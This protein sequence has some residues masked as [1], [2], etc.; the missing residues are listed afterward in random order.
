MAQVEEWWAHNQDLQ[1]PDKERPF[2]V[3]D[4][5]MIAHHGGGAVLDTWAY[6]DGNNCLFVA[7]G[8]TMKWS[9]DAS[10][11]KLWADTLDMGEHATRLVVA[12]TSSPAYMC[13]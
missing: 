3:D 2:A 10:S 12:L 13:V 11:H 1:H 7:F 4:A 6:E 5:V 9:T 8:N